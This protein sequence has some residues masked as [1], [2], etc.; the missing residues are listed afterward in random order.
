MTLS[1]RNTVLVVM[2][3]AA[4]L[5]LA[6]GIGTTVWALNSGGELSA[7]LEHPLQVWWSAQRDAK[8]QDLLW[9]LGA[10]LLVPAGG[11]VG[12]ALFLVSFRKTAAPEIFLFTVM[13]L[14]LAFDA[15]RPAYLLLDSYDVP[16]YFGV[17]LSRVVYFG[18]FFGLFCAFGASLFAVGTQY[19]RLG[20]ILMVA[21]VLSFS[22]AYA[23]QIDSLGFMATLQY[24]LADGKGIAVLFVALQALAVVNFVAG[25]YIRGTS[26][27]VFLAIGIALAS[28]GRELTFFPAGPVHVLGGTALLLAGAVVFAKKTY[29]LYLWS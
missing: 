21:F 12:G 25:S 9:V 27:Y 5:L 16:W 24:R 7:F 29:A 14:S 3:A 18:R 10:L 2:L 6:V 26:D 28:V 4:L 19:Q 1:S 17:V 22:L 20:T 11:I 23:V 15:A 8:P 13:L